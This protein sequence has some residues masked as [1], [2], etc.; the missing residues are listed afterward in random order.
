MEAIA[1]GAASLPLF[2]D[3]LAR[4][5]QR[6]TEASVRAERRAADTP[7]QMFLPG[8]D[9][10]AMPNHLNRSSI[11]APIAR[12]RRKY[13][14]QTPMVT[15]S[16]VTMSYT[17]EQLD[18]ADADLTMALIF[19]AKN[20]RFGVP[21]MLNRAALLR[22]MGRCTGNHDYDWLHRRM[23]ALTEGT[24]F[25]EARKRDGSPKYRIGDTKAFHILSGFDYDD[26]AEIYSYT[27]DPRWVM[28][29]S[30]REYALL[31]WK[32]RLQIRSSQHMA[33][34]LQRLVAA[35]SDKVQ[36][37]P[38]DWLKE[39]MQYTSPIRKFRSAVATAVHELERVGVIAAG[40]IE[41]STKG[42]EQLA[43]WRSG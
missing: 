38:L 26:D 32:K 14:R 22:S 21:V 36:R 23:K 10:G 11:Y 4:V 25:I 8:F 40:R 7:V 28:L 43:L 31:D 12:G 37:Y 9:I 3:L 29:F 24:L 17:G 34:T 5:R 30:N 19:A 33:K 35:S 2:D 42:R 39:K 16:D 27:L 18:E 20:Q 15:R 13:H 1:Q 6:A 41:I